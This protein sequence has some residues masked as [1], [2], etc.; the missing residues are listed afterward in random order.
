VL[1]V[2]SA[3]AL[4]AGYL[5]FHST[6]TRAVQVAAADLPAFHQI[7]SADLSVTAVPLEEVPSR[8][9]SSSTALVGRYTLTP[10]RRGRP[11]NLD[12]LGPRLPAN[13]LADRVV[14]SLATTTTDVGDGLVARGDTV[15][16]L[17][18]ST[19]TDHPR[20]GLLR[21]VLVLDVRP[22]AKRPDQVAVVCAVGRSD[23]MSLLDAG[24]TA[25]LFIVRVTPSSSP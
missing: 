23:E 9:T 17:L 16:I 14:I 24:G 21:Q 13:A 19:S 5:W 22:D 7:T 15:D 18:S 12:N 3:C 2:L 10:T 6:R 4:G 8:A 25:R 20:S 1:A 11:Y